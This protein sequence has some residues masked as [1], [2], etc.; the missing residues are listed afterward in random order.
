MVVSQRF[1]VRK[2]KQVKFTI[3]KEEYFLFQLFR[4]RHVIGDDNRQPFELTYLPAQEQ[5]TAATV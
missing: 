4:F 3:A 1:K 5:A 2:A